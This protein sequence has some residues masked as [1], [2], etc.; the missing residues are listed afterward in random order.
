MRMSNILY[1][2]E[3]EESFKV[4][5]IVIPADTLKLAII[6]VELIL[7]ESALNCVT[8]VHTLY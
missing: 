5:A 3:F 6:Q 7:G 2:F 1:R 4:N 8:S